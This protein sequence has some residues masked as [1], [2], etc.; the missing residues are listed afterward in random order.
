M[1]SRINDL[2]LK[3]VTFPVLSVLTASSEEVRIALADTLTIDE[4]NEKEV[5]RDSLCRKY[6]NEYDA[7]LVE[8]KIELGMT[9]EM[10]QVVLF[11]KKTI[12]LNKSYD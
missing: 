1:H 2:F 9:K 10:C 7:F 5:R 12:L 4:L 3:N 11:W 8:N 6:G